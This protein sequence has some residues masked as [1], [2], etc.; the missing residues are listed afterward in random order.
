MVLGF[1]YE[2]REDG[3][4]KLKL[5]IAISLMVFC[6][7][8]SLAELW[9]IGSQ[10]QLTFN[11]W[12]ETHA[13]PSPDGQSI[14]YTGSRT[15][16]E[17]EIDIFNVGTGVTTQLTDNTSLN[18]TPSFTR[19]G[20]S[21]LYSS[22]TSGQGDNWNISKMNVDGTV[23]ID[24]TSGALN[25]AMPNELPGGKIVYQTWS[26]GSCTISIMDADGS[27][28]NV[29]TNTVSNAQQPRISNSGQYITYHSQDPSGS[30]LYD[31]YIYDLLASPENAE[32][33]LTFESAL[34]GFPSFSL[35]DELI[36]YQSKEDGGDYYDLWIL[37]WQSGVKQQL[38]FDNFDQQ[39][40]VFMPDGS[41]IIYSSNQDGGVYNDMW[42]LTPEPASLS[43]L[44]LGGLILR[45]RKP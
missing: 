42:L 34:Q 26:S 15:L 28:M 40:P 30:M 25:E 17:Y 23:K 38:T 41:G 37:N 4:M 9:N 8:N 27:N 19:D 35:D 20:L 32:T 44:A 1:F 14:V 12:H 33:Q 5:F 3:K 29:L 13:M 2:E 45:R 36:V 31:L 16:G 21:I 22:D 39:F 7:S 11:D 18:Q 6:S 24:L 43:L 10:V